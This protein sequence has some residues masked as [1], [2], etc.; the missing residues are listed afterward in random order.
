[1]NTNASQMSQMIASFSPASNQRRWVR[2]NN[3]AIFDGRQW[4]YF[5][6][7]DVIEDVMVEAPYDHEDAGRW[8]SQSVS[9]WVHSSGM[10]FDSLAD[11]QAWWQSA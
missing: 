9:V 8:V 1:M 4:G 7:R 11:A 5:R 6:R 10:Q 3:A 2:G